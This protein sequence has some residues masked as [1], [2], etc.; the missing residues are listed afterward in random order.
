MQKLGQ[1]IKG[2]SIMKTVTTALVLLCITCSMALSQF[3]RDQTIVKGEYFINTDPSEGNGISIT[4]NNLSEITVNVSS[5]DLP[6]GSRLYVRFKSS[7]GKWSGP[8]CILRKEYFSN[9]GANLVYAEYFINADP[10]R[11]NGTPIAINPDGTINLNDPLLKRGDKVYFR[12]K[13]SYNRWSDARP[14]K[15]RFKDMYR[16]EYYI[17]YN[18]GGQT[19]PATMAFNPAND[20]SSIFTTIRRDVSA[21]NGDVVF[22]R[23]QTTER[24]FSEWNSTVVTPSNSITLSIVEGWNMVSIPLTVSDYRRIAIY[25]IAT[26]EAFAY[27]LAGYAQFDTMMNRTGYW[28]KFPSDQSVSIPGASRLKDTIQLFAGWNLIGSISTPVPTATIT[29]NPPGLVTSY[30]YGYN[31]SIGYQRTDTIQPGDAYWVKVDQVGQLKL[32]ASPVAS[33][34]SRIRIIPSSELPPPPPADSRHLTSNIPNDFVLD[35]NYPNP[36]NPSTT[37]RY[38]LPNTSQVTLTAYN[39][40]GQRVALLVNE[41][42]DAGYHEAVLDGSGL[43]S[44]VYFYKLSASDPSSSTGQGF[45]ETRK[46]LLMK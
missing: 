42:Q 6:V 24:F 33:P 41:R 28:M 45:V 9:S 25:P 38:G 40:L 12:L 1:I 39:T 13:D 21:S 22:V 11:G 18:G 35:Q 31:A 5:I 26:S 16:A 29:S 4:T 7:N 44:G 19:S 37:I 46:L 15:F 30:F 3:Q 34:S 8:R 36:F 32:S 10:S 23:A 2:G 20:S 14:V 17:K 43:S 27:T